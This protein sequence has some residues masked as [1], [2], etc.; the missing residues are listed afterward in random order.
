MKVVKVLC[1]PGLTGFYADDKEAIRE[2]AKM[3]GFIYRGQ[4][5]TPGFNSIRQAG[6]SVSI[7]FM[8]EN[9]NIAYG[10]CAIAQYTGSGGRELANTADNLI[11]IINKYLVP[12]YEGK[13][14]FGFKEE[15][16]NIDGMLF[17]GERLPVSIRY[18]VTQAIL[19]TVSL[20]QKITMAEVVA[21]EYGL[22][23][24]RKPVLLNAQSGDER[25]T[26]VDKM[27]VKKK[28]WG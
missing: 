5:L 24:K 2:G 11:E 4:P 16:E 6:E 18:G 1:S 21:S 12:Y 28:S 10:D 23:L 26:N 9:G 22:E 25:Y 13:E 8:L 14:I 7:I 17:E 19:E 27:I 3:D 20:A 15:A